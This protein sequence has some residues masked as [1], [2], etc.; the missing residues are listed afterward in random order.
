MS[1]PA[2]SNALHI[3]HTCLDSSIHTHKWPLHLQTHQVPN[4][5]NGPPPIKPQPKA[6]LLRSHKCSCNPLISSLTSPLS[7]TLTLQNKSYRNKSYATAESAILAKTQIPSQSTH[8]TTTSKVSGSTSP[9]T[10]FK[11]VDP[12]LTHPS[13]TTTI[14]SRRT[15]SSTM[16]ILRPNTKYPLSQ[17][18]SSLTTFNPTFSRY[19]N[20]HQVPSA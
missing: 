7:F 5:S 6:S 9:K 1:P 10:N 11:Q 15:T 14:I 16:C 3:S 13:A 20:V 12:V 17:S 2:I 18:R 8:S 4:P 19:N